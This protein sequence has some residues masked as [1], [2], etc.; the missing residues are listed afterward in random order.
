MEKVTEKFAISLHK[1][2]DKQAILSGKENIDG[3]FNLSRDDQGKDIRTRGY[4]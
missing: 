1:S 3:K 2:Q 4:G